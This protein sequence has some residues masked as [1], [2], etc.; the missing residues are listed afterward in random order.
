MQATTIHTITTE[1][2]CPADADVI[3]FQHVSRWT[4]I[5]MGARSR[6]VIRTEDG[7]MVDVYLGAGFC[8]C[9]LVIK[10]NQSDLYDIEIGRVHRRMLDWIPEAQ[11]RD[12][13]AE[14]LDQAIRNLYDANKV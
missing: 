9:C 11:M 3:W 2:G 7:L 6:N 12:I 8:K 5:A 4:W 13:H 1:K 14:Q 10:V